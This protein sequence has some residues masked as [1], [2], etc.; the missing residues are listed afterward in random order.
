MKENIKIF[1]TFPS[2][3]QVQTDMGSAK[4]R[5][6]PVTVEDSAKGIIDVANMLPM[7]ESGA[8]MTFQGAKLPY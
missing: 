7:E 1:Q 8:F 6:P 3:S 5:S 4:N 2:F